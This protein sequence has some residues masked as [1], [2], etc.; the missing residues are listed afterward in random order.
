MV[1]LESEKAQR[2]ANENAQQKKINEDK[3]AAL[4]LQE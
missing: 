4:K 3:K 1:K 2:L